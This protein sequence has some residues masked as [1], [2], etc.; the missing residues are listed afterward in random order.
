MGSRNLKVL[1]LSPQSRITQDLGAALSMGMTVSPSNSAPSASRQR[2][3]NITSSQ[4]L[5][6]LTALGETDRAA[7]MIALC[8]QDFEGG[9]FTLPLRVEGKTVT[10]S[11]TEKC[12]VKL[13]AFHSFQLARTETLVQH[14]A[15]IV[16]TALL[17]VH[18]QFT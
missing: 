3:V 8:E 12:G 2:L 1:P 5:S 13:G 9:A 14:K 7:H 18:H 16:S 15:H 6:D 17:I 11:V 10:M 4:P